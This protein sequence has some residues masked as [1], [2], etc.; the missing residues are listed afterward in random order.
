MIYNFVTI[1]NNLY[2]PQAINLH[3]SLKNFSI[4]F[5][6]WAICIDKE[7]Y[8]CIKKLSY[9]TFVPINFSKYENKKLDKLKKE[10]S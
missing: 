9:K 2:L 4:R 6:L 5:K 7:S 8:N 3:K 1:F 10:R